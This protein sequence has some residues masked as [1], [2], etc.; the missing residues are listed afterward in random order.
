[1]IL[2][3][4]FRALTDVNPEMLRAYR[5]AANAVTKYRNEV[6]AIHRHEL[7]TAKLKKKQLA[8]TVRLMR[9]ANS[10]LCNT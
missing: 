6:T 2:R 8:A 5:R 1:M 7:I 4:H 3:K 9:F 10:V